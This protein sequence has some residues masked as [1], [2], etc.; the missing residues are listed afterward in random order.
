MWVP[1]TIADPAQ[2][3][4]AAIALVNALGNTSSIYG[5]F[6]WPK[7]DAPQYVPGFSATTVWMALICILAPIAGW[8][9]KKHERSAPDA[10]TVMAAEAQAQKEHDLK[11]HNGHAA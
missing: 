9:F 8:A 5:V 6:L 11:Q 4:A 7:A 10:E 3:R 2:K 1:N